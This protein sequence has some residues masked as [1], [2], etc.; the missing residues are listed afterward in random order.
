M[1]VHC[2]ICFFRNRFSSRI[3]KLGF[4]APFK[5]DTSKVSNVLDA[6]RAVCNLPTSH[7]APCWLDGSIGPDPAEIVSCS[8]G[9]LHI[10]TRRLMAPTPRFFTFNGL[11]FAYD[12]HAPQPKNWLNFINQIWP[13]DFQSRD[14]LREWIGYLLTPVTRMQKMLILIG[15]KR[16]G[17]GTIGRVIRMLLGEG[18][19]CTPTLAG[20]AESFGL[21]SLIGK[22][23]AIISDARISGRADTTIVTERLLSISGEDPQTIPRKFLP[24]WIGILPTRFMLMTNELPKLEDA[25]GTLASRFIILALTESFYGR[26]D[27]GLLDRFVPE[28]PG[29]LLWALEGWEQVYRRGRFIQP[30]S[31]LELI[32][33]FEDLGSPIGAFVRD[34]CEVR[35]GF[36]IPQDRLFESWKSWCAENGNEH[37]G[38]LHIFSRNLQSFVPG[39]KVTR[40]RVLGVQVQ[41][42][43]GIRL[44]THPESP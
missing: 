42:C 24:D 40:P 15:P 8:N 26:E 43:V 34:R 14:T 17:K 13:D 18:N 28:L 41:Y 29:I 5:P 20:M 36:E 38:T 2:S 21:A 44:K 30:D 25:S 7:T 35:P 31:A 6:L 33:Q 23:A 39:L 10:P 11:E 37:P 22:S 9:L 12:P 3:L 16:A 27:H 32:N 4:V 1:P 19:I